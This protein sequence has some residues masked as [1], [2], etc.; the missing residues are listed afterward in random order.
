MRLTG[1]QSL[2]IVKI[3][4]FFKCEPDDLIHAILDYE[5]EYLD[6]VRSMSAIEKQI[7]KKYK[8]AQRFKL[9]D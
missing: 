8:I 7:I 5:L 4:R 9:L 1:K 2:L 3:S 6:K